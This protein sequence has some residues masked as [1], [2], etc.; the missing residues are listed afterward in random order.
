MLKTAYMKKY[1]K[2]GIM[3]ILAAIVSFLF[4]KPEKK[5]VKSTVRSY[6]EIIQ[7][8]VLRAITE[9]NAFSFHAQ[10][11]TVSGFHYELIQ[12]FAKSKNLKV[13]IIPEMSLEK[14]IQGVESGEYDILA[15][16]VL[17][18][19]NR[20]DSIQYTHPIFLSKEVLVQRKPKDENDSSY[21]HSL[22]D[23]GSK[24][25]HL[26][27]NSSSIYRIQNVIFE[28]GDTIFIK[29]VEK[30]GTEQLIAMIANGEIDY[31]VCDESIAQAVIKNFPQIDIETAVS[32]TQFYS[33]GVKKS[34]TALLDTL[35]AW[36]DDFTQTPAFEE[37]VKK[38]NNSKL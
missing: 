25:L 32:F 34:N 23:L 2:Y 12:A 4:L 24:T 14:R 5:E 3:G 33:W 27:K 37:L 17:K 28:I 16:N 9:Y 19:S 10:E 35:N 22:L 20:K 1:L 29:E 31:T 30:Y 11:D 26:V 21:I 36:I 7:S 13:D 18:T 6:E 38:Y 8:G 15:N